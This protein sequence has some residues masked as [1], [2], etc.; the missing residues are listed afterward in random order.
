MSDPQAISRSESIGSIALWIAV[1]TGPLAWAT[2]LAVAYGLEDAIACAPATSRPGTIVGLSVPVAVLLLNAVLLGATLLAGA[3]G[4]RCLVRLRDQ[5]V[6]T[7]GR[8]R[9][10]ALAGVINSVLFGL[11]IAVG[12]IPAFVLDACMESF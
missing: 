11:I 2:Q 4:W 12:F 3:L 1:L 10:M 5:D 7:A 9:W 8:A 6:T